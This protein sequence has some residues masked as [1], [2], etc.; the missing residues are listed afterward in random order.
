M[1]YRGDEGS[2]KV[3]KK[4]KVSH[5]HAQSI[6]NGGYDLCSSQSQGDIFVETCLKC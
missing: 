5:F 4:E 1:K 2:R 6:D 3:D